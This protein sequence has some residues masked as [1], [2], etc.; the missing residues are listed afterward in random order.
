MKGFT[1]VELMVVFLIFTII[2]GA[3][4]A[5]LT[6]GRTS[7]Y[8]GNTQVEMQQETR[9]GMDSMVRELRQSGSTTIVGVPADGNF[10]NSI[11]FRVPQDADGDGDVLDVSGNVEW[12]NQITYSLG[13]LGGQQLLRTEGS[14]VVVLANS[15]VSLQFRRQAATSNIVEMTL[16][17]QKTTIPGHLIGTTINSEVML[18]N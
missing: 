13:G 18:R 10:Y 11:T 7:W 14:Q 17:S 5:V 3:I 16:Q 15:I 4:F 8:S 9:R 1:L 2:M 6:M 12:G